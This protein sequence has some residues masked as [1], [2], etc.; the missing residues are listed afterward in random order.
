MSFISSTY[1]P[2]SNKSILSRQNIHQNRQ[3]FDDDEVNLILLHSILIQTV[4]SIIIIIKK[5][6]YNPMKNHV[7]TQSHGDILDLSLNLG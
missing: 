4:K 2:N 3:F 7:H 6:T 5:K 1:C